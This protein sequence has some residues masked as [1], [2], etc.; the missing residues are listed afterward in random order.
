M[1]H[2]GKKMGM[3]GKGAPKKSGKLKLKGDPHNKGGFFKGDNM[4]RGI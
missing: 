3:S 4:K 1:K 2:R